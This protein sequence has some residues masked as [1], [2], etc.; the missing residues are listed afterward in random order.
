PD[1]EASLPDLLEVGGRPRTRSAIALNSS[2]GNSARQPTGSNRMASMGCMISRRGRLQPDLWPELFQP[3]RQQALGH[4]D[5]H[6]VV[7]QRGRIDECLWEDVTH[8]LGTQGLSLEERLDRPF[9][10]RPPGDSAEHHAGAFV[11]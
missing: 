1:Q 4:L 2:A 6:R 11:E 8:Q 9:T 10:E 7:F 3:R 5:L